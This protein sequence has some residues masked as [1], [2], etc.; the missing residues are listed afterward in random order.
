MRNATKT[1]PTHRNQCLRAFGAT[2]VLLAS[3]QVS[4]CAK[5]ARTVKPVSIGHTETGIA[6]WYGVPYHGRKAANGEVFDMNELTA[7]HPSLPFGTWVQVTNLTNAKRIVVRITDRGPF[8]HGR[9]IDLSREAAKRI[10]M[11]G[12]GTAR[13]EVKVVRRRVV[14]TASEVY[15]PSDVLAP[16][17]QN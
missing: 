17:S 8:V 12:P 9:I 4:A 3:L 5:H 10:D 15:H 1:A 6:S 11:I 16:S 14:S 7:A 2:C 13:V